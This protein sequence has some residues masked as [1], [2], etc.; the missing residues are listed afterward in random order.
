MPSRSL[1]I[2]M[3]LLA[4]LSSAYLTG[5]V[6][7]RAALQARLDAATMQAQ[8]AALETSKAL[9]VAEQARRAI[10][11]QMEDAANADPVAVPVCLSADRV[12]R[13]SAR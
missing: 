8:A 12:R 11:A 9:A 7:G 13:L 6:Q 1:I 5:R 4:A 3:I 2:A 10:S